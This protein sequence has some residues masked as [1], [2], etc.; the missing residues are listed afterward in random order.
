[1]LVSSHV[2]DEVARLGSRVLVIAQGRLI[3]QGDYHDLRDLMDDRPHRDPARG[4]RPAR[5]SQ[6]RSSTAAW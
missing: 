5:A 3:A 4:V 6:P 2:L 1:M